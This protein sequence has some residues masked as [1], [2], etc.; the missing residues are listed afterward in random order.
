[1][2]HWQSVSIVKLAD[3]GEGIA[4]SSVPLFKALGQWWQEFKE[5]LRQHQPEVARTLFALM[6]LAVLVA[7][8]LLL[9]EARPMIWLAAQVD[10]LRLGLFAFHAPG[11][12]GARQYYDAMQRLLRLHDI[13]RPATANAREYLALIAWRHEHLQPASAAMTTLFEKARYGHAAVDEA[14]VAQMRQAYRRLYHRIGAAE[15]LAR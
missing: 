1:M 13:E 8:W 6:V 5:W 4:F 2:P 14:E 11:N 7:A 9:K 10:F 12:D 15:P 3:L